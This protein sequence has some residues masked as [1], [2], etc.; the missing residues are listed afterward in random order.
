[1]LEKTSESTQLQ[2]RKGAFISANTIKYFA[3]FAMLIDHIAWCFV[4]TNSILGIIMHLIG[5]MTAPIMTYFIVEGYHYTRNVNKY[6]ARLAIF[7]AVSWIPFL[8]MEYGTFLPFTFV[9]GNLY[10]NPA[11]G[12]IYTFFLT[13]LALKTVHSQSLP[14]PAKVVLVIGL[15]M[16]SSIGDWFFFPIVWALLLDKYRGNF[17]K[18]A[19]AFAISSVVLMTLMIVFLTDGFGDNWFQY[20]V[21]LALIPLYFYNGEKGRGGRFNKWFFYIFYPAHLLILGILKW[22][23]FK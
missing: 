3:V 19:A 22:Y 21:L 18:Q 11:Q 7:A 1:M 10:F 9:D 23:V 5:R 17:K 2:T 4:D 20:G 16:L 14:K 15:C 12:V 8:F 13:L 6:L